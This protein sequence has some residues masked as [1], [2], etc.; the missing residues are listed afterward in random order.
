MRTSEKPAIVKTPQSLSSFS[1]AHFWS[2]ILTL[3]YTPSFLTAFT[4]DG[5]LSVPPVLLEVRAGKSR[6][7]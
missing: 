6:Y 5:A 4:A 3:H 7:S 2:V 1:A